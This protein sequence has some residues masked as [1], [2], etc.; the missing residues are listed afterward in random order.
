[1]DNA[2][3]ISPVTTPLAA[4][5]DNGPDV[6]VLKFADSKIPVFKEVRGKDY[7]RYGEDNMYPEYLT[8]L[9]DK[10]GK[11]GAIVSGKAA[12]IY[13]EGYENGDFVVNRLDETL[14]DVCKKSILDIP[15]YGGF[16]NEVVYDRLGRVCEIYH[17]D[18]NTLRLS[19]KGDGYYWKETW[20]P[21]DS[22]SREQEEFI[23]L[24]DPSKPYGT[25]IFAYVEYRPGVRFYPLPEFIATNN[26]IETDIEIS[27]Y[28]LS[29]IRNGMMPSKMMQF[30]TGEPSDDKK[31]E[32][33]RRMTQKYA[34]AENA[35]RFIFVFNSTKEK[36]VQV[37]DLS[38][39]ELDK[40][41][42]QVNNICQQEIFSGHKVTSPMLFGIKTE[43]QLG[44]NT[45]LYTAYAIFQN[46][47]S[48]PKAHT[49]D[50]QMQKVMSRSRWPGEYA[51]RPTDPIGI[52][53]DVKDVINALPKA[54]V[55]EKLG[56]PKEMW[57]LENIGS[58]NR[59]TP[60]TP[61]PPSTRIDAP[62][63][64]A[65]DAAVNDAIRNLST[66]Q[67]QQLLRVIRQYGKGQLTELAARTLLRT[68][69]G[70]ADT[71]IDNLLGVQATTPAAMSLTRKLLSV[72]LKLSEAEAERVITMSAT[73]NEEDV[74]INIFDSFGDCKD[75][76]EI[77]KS[78]KVVFSTD[79]EARE[80]E[81]LFIETAFKD[82]DVTITEDRIIEL[83]RKD[84]RITSKVI[85]DTIGQTVAYVE[86]KIED[87][88][89]LGYLD[90]TTETE[91][92]DT[93][94]ER[95]IPEDVSVSAPPPRA[96]APNPAAV[97]VKYSYEVKPGIG[98]AVIKTTRPF[99]RRM[100]ALNRIYSRADIEKI[101]VRL[102]YSVWDRKGGWW[103]GN[104]E[105]RHRWVSH[106][107]IKKGGD[108]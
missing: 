87:L 14:N 2:V 40:L 63:I 7:I 107:V 101:S 12:Y 94:V 90:E 50:R 55:F 75:D 106:V 46:T 51:L 8:Y 78:K 21:K 25:Q 15:T 30:F 4:V 34:G 20:N 6:I 95:T 71:D 27:K 36:T 72:S 77:L 5:K 18:F 17:V 31:R 70:L 32:I 85:A 98:P 13:G 49:F 67:H 104:P 58:D 19:K 80:D 44:G 60:T 45:E 102:G 65:A 23:P 24:Y 1:M 11:H 91:G 57:T 37:D 79:E 97:Y 69:L 82:Y 28:N 83:I 38:A 33:E 96:G 68:G 100:I 52:Q 84:K 59:P 22:K 10:S 76:F 64:P 29:T 48:K 92:E 53:F 74:M 86:N 73:Y 47:Y 9:F 3:A 81:S 39:T 54:F 62:G 16:Y 26:Y 105:C 99:C 66:K 61:I 108:K 103:G 93:I 88:V 89:R 56:I 42:A 43:G 35:G 41:F